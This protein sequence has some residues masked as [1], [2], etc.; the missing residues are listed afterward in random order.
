MKP[1]AILIQIICACLVPLGFGLESIL[2]IPL[3]GGLPF[4]TLLAAVAL[5]AGS[6][7]PLALGRKGSWLRRTGSLVLVAAILWLPLG[8]V[9]SG[10]AS[11]NFVQDPLDSA[12]FWRYTAVLA[13][14]TLLTIF[15]AGIEAFFRRS[16]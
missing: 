6:A 4:G 11:L 15:W 9:L 8:I 13:A 7:I 14:V 2:L 12:F 16:D 10:N 5:V 3:P 1:A